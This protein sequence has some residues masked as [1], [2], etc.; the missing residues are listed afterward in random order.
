VGTYSLI[1]GVAFCTPCKD[2]MITREPGASSVTDCVKSERTEHAVSIMHRMLNLIRILLAALLTTTFI[3]TLTSCYCFYRKYQMSFQGGSKTMGR[4]ETVIS[5]FRIPW[6]SPQAG[7][8][9]GPVS[10]TSH[11][12]TSTPPGGDEEHTFGASPLV[13][14]PSL[15]DVT[16]ETMPMLTREERMRT[17]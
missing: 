14:A 1:Y 2:G 7:P 10:D 16:D 4:M 12:N 11:L 15:A 6:Q 9:A 3:T 13:A 8:E 5:F 17:F